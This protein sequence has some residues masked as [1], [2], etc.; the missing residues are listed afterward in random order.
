LARQTK[1]AAALAE[2]VRITLTG[3]LA[4]HQPDDTADSLIARADKLLEAA[5]AAGRNRIGTEA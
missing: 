5:K 1:D 3:G 4:W 2:P